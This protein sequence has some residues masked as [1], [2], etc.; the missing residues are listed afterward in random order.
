[1]AE[2]FGTGFRPTPPAPP[3][4][5]GLHNTIQ[6]GAIYA[7]VPGGYENAATN[8]AF[9]AGRRA[10]ANHTG[11]FVWG[12]STDTDFAST[13]AN[14]FLIRAQGGVG[15]NTNNP[16]ATLHVAGDIAAEALRAPGAGINTG[17]Y[18]FVHRAVAT[19][20]SG[21]WT[22]IYNSHADSD[23]G[24]MVIVTHNWTADT[25]SVTR[26]NT[27]PVGVYYT[28]GHWAIFNEDQSSM[29]LGRAFNVLIVKP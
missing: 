18:A 13:A 10:K 5:G 17:T 8:F 19:N 3:S 1:M 24:A 7:T 20:T 23:P 28:G 21:N 4:A 16:Q 15:V 6:T 25:N 27:T 9:A 2:D 12:D 29:D 26:Y 14:Q 11:A 22:T